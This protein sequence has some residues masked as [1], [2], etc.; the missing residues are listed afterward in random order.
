MLFSSLV[1]LYIFLPAVV[2]LHFLIPLKLKNTWLLVSSLVFYFWGEQKYIYVIFASIL[3]NYLCGR[4]IE[5]YRQCG[6][7]N[8]ENK[9]LTKNKVKQNWDNSSK[10]LFLGLLLNLSLLF[11]FKYFNFAV[12][13]IN[14]LFTFLK[15][16]FAFSNEKV[17]LP[18]GISF[19]TFQGIAYLV[20][21]YRRD[22][23]SEKSFLNYSLYTILFPQLIAGPI[24]LMS[25]VKQEIHSRKIQFE[26]FIEGLQRFI[27]GLSKKVLIA[28]NV[29]IFVDQTFAIPAN[30]IA[31][32]TAWLAIIGY[33]LQIFFDFSGYSDMAIGIGKMLGFNFVENFNYPYISKS[34]TEFWRRWNISLSSWFRDYLYIPLGGSRVSKNKILVNL[35]LVFFLTGFWHGASWSFIVWGLFNGFWVIMER[36][37]LKS[38]FEKLPAFASHLYAVPLILISW[39]FFRADTLSYALTFIQQMF[40]FSNIY[41]PYQLIGFMTVENRIFFVLGIFFIL[42]LNTYIIKLKALLLKYL[43]KYDKIWTVLIKLGVN[44]SSRI[45]LVG[46][47]LLSTLYLIVNTYNPF[48]YFRF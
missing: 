31:L 22:I 40:N 11:Y 23:T 41:R 33:A 16:D 1:F 26:S 32:S 28:N 4:A 12:E 34:I 13:N 20:D 43:S 3:I 30:E 45:A 19:F 42:P 47:F 48:I 2:L 10:A 35:L 27:L 38:F 9:K 8:E 37:Y 5:Y 18:I 25:Q 14:S 7:F 6:K 21:V 15:L 24:I 39:V 46:L 17:H 36:L 44:L 29:A